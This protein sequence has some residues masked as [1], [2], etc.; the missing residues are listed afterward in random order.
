MALHDFPICPSLYESKESHYVHVALQSK[1]SFKF[2]T[3][4]LFT[5]FIKLDGAIE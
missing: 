1:F 3:F 2:F 4:K 5:K